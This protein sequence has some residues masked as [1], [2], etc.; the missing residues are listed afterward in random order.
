[1]AIPLANKYRPKTFE[2][3]SEQGAIKTIIENQIKNSDLRNAYLFCGGAGT[4]KTTCAR[5][6]ADMIND[7]K[8]NPIEL[9]AAS[10]NSVDDVRRIITDSKFKSL[11][12][13]YKIYII[14]ECHSLSNAA[15]Q[16]MLK[17]LEEP[18]KSTIFIFCTTDP[19]KIPGTILSRVQRYNFQ[20]ISKQ[21]II[22]RLKYII[23]QENKEGN[24]ITYDNEALDYIAK[25]ARG[26]MR[27]AI[28][29]LDKCLAFSKELTL[30][31]VVD[32]L[33]AGV[34]PYDLNQ[35][36]LC[37]INKDINNSLTCLNN[38]YM[39]GIDMSLLVTNYFDFLLNLQ[40]YLVLGSSE[41]SNLPIDILQ[42]YNG[43]Q[44]NIIRNYLQK[45]FTVINAPKMDIK[46]L[47]EAWVIERCI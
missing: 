27:D 16:A 21:G 19:Q 8:G 2:D 4:G 28:T 31:N 43:S 25:Q 18:P 7:G 29:T 47:L 45:L 26:G 20:R 17:L 6:V 12:S 38:F 22:N 39:S 24:I 23:E 3:V 5:I 14:D 40:K 9:D 30:K 11:D 34:T 36:T 15:W 33:S 46:S 37:L 32:V 13:K 10:N 42:Q 35:F 44:A 1:M 41:A